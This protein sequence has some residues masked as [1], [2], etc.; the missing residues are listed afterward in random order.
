MTTFT[1]TLNG[2]PATVEWAQD[3]SLL[4]ALTGPLARRDTQPGCG[5]GL[6]GA[7]TVLVDGKPAR[8]CSTRLSEVAGRDILTIDGLRQRGHPLVTAWRAAG[9]PEDCLCPGGRLLAFAALLA[10]N[11]APTDAEIDA[12]LDN[13]ICECG[14][15][16]RIRGAVRQASG[17]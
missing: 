9:L 7:C 16:E 12:I 5:I 1:F 10:D 13:T 14:L 8:A 6:C 2:E 11:P 15:E 3:L 17:G 4:E